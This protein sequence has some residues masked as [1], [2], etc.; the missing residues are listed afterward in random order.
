MC[1]VIISVASLEWAEFFYIRTYEEYNASYACY[2]Y[3][4]HRDSLFAI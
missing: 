1:L 4:T 2:R 3:E